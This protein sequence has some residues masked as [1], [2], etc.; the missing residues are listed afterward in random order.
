MNIFTLAGGS[1]ASYRT[2]FLTQTSTSTPSAY[3]VQATIGVAGNPSNSLWGAIG[4]GAGAFVAT[5]N[6]V[7]SPQAKITY[8]NG[9]TWNNTVPNVNISADIHSAVIYSETTYLTGAGG[10]VIPV[11]YVLGKNSSNTIGISGKITSAGGSSWTKDYPFG[12]NFT[13][14]AA[15]ADTA[16]IFNNSSSYSRYVNYRSSNM[17]YWSQKDLG[18]GIKNFVAAAS[19]GANAFIGI[20]QDTDKAYYSIDNAASWSTGILPA[21][22][23]WQ[24]IAYGGGCFMVVASGTSTGAI[25]LNNGTTWSPITLSG[26][27]RAWRDVAYGNGMFMVVGEPDASIYTVDRGTTW[28]SLTFPLSNF[29]PQKI[30][31]G[32]NTFVAIASGIKVCILQNLQPNNLN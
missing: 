24:S 21:S 5:H 6:N 27:V 1:A 17:D 4:Y 15:G 9:V 13:A 14:I 12:S 22:S 7:N 30:A 32:N 19:D 18:V 23:K 11:W 16:V 10:Q 3:W 26:T 28:K 8:D 31:Y 29:N 20:A 2:I 25:S